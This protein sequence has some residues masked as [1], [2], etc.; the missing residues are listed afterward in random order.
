MDPHTLLDILHTAE[1]L[2]DTI[3]HCYTSGGRPESV[4]EHS[5]RVALMAMLIGDEFPQLDMNRVI[6]MCLIHD[7]GECFTGDIPT[8]DKTD[9]HRATEEQLLHQWV[10][11]LPE[12]I[13]GQWTA[14]YTEMDAQETPESKLCKA[15]DK[16][17]AV[18]QHNESDIQTWAPNEYDLN[19]VYGYDHVAFSPYLTALRDE[20]KAETLQKMEQGK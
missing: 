16:L 5:W 18:I 12:P 6:K 15:L 11:T 9:A 8:F 14:L 19:L 3:R 7:L 4:A 10:Q 20:I 17:E 1:R 2:K 13:S